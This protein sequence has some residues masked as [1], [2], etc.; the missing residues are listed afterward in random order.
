MA[1]QTITHTINVTVGSD[2]IQVEPNTL[3]MSAL[4][5]VQWSG[6]NARAFSIEFDQA[7]PFASRQL[8]HAA[9]RSAQRPANKGRFKYTVVSTDDPKLRLDPIIIV[10]DPPTEP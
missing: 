2:S 7:S 4:D 1:V 10:Q 8:P 6:T 9:A 3:T 5:S